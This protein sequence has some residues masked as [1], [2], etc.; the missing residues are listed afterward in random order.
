MAPSRKPMRTTSGPTTTTTNLFKALKRNKSVET[1]GVKEKSK[2][3]VVQPSPQNSSPQSIKKKAISTRLQQQLNKKRKRVEEPVEL[4]NKQKGR[5]SWNLY[6]HYMSRKG[7][8]NLEQEIFGGDP[9][10]EIDR[11]STWLRARCDKDGNYKSKE[12]ETIAEDIVKVLFLCSSMAYK[13]CEKETR[14]RWR[15][16][17]AEEKDAEK[18]EV[19][20]KDVAEEKNGVEDIQREEIGEEKGS[21]VLEVVDNPVDNP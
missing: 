13:C 10:M 12:I 6:G 4:H 20:E 19:V 7:Y 5:R 3:N 18:D 17:S 21:E 16:R 14:S 1:C 11:S 8:A 2:K 15:S 9:E